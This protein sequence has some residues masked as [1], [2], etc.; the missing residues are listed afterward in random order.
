MRGRAPG[1]LEMTVTR[2]RVV[3]LLAAAASTPA[4]LAFP[5]RAQ[6]VWREYRRDDLG[7]RVELPAE[8]EVEE[9]E[10]EGKDIVVR[11][12]DAQVDYEMITFGVNHTEYKNTVSPD[13]EF[14]VFREGMQKFGYPVTRETPLTSYGVPAREFIC[15]SDDLNII[16]RVLVM[17]KV[18]IGV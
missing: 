16:H 3:S 1:G 13:E 9:K 2:R 10:D 15:Q 14:Q 4:V 12:I 17:G 8:P 11:S 18:T 6:D 5:A 7:F